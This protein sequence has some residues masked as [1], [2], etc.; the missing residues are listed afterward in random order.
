MR[1]IKIF[2]SYAKPDQ[3]RAEALYDR[4]CLH[5]FEPWMDSRNILPGEQ[6]EVRIWET[7]KNA[8]LIVVCLTSNSITRR[9]FIQREIRRGLELAKEKLD[10]DIFLIPV[11][12]EECQVPRLLADYQWV[13]L[14]SNEGWTKLV[15]AMRIGFLRQ[16]GRQEFGSEPPCAALRDVVANTLGLAYNKIT[17][18]DYQR[19]EKLD[20]RNFPSKH[21]EGIGWLA[22]LKQ[23]VLIRNG[24]KDLSFI[25]NLNNLEILYLDN[26]PVEDLSPLSN[27]SQLKYLSLQATSV[28]DLSP[29]RNLSNLEQL[30]LNRSPVTKL[31]P[32]RSLAKLAIL[33]LFGTGVSEE[34]LADLWDYRSELLVY[35]ENPF[36]KSCND[37]I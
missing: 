9:G 25:G 29:L 20:L 24:L 1:K 37:L 19:V 22:N 2:L 28:T 8:D 31:A 34:E 36:D 7:L 32:L 15:S 17:L 11:R 14:F 16:K 33:H 21:I 10:E 12:L 30:L 23:L 3:E 18:E 4:L 27:L 26:N 5:G 35:S 6:W 13:D